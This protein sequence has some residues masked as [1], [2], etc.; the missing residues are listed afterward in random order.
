MKQKS[1]G[2]NYIYNLILTG[3]N[4]AFPL[5]TASYLSYILGA[6]NIGKV[7]YATSIINWFIIFASFGIPR[8]GVRAIARSRD[9]KKELSETFW[10][11]MSIQ[12]IFTSV[13]VCI[14]IAF[15]VNI[16]RFEEELILHLL[17]VLML[18]LN[19]FS[20][21]WFYQGI[22]E[23]GYITVRSILFK[24]I[25]IILMFALIKSRNDYII[26]AFINIIGV[27]L[28]N[29]LNY[30]HSGKFIYRK[31]PKLNI[32]HYIKE[33]R[34][35]FVTTL[36]IAIYG[37]LDQLFIGTISPE[38]L[39]YYIRSKTLL[40][41]GISVTNSV[42]TVLIPRS[43]YLMENDYKQ[44]K[45]V[46]QQS[47]NYIYI[48]GVPCVIGLIL[49]SEEVM[50]LLGGLEFLPAVSSLQI[51]SIQIIIV[52]IGGWQVNQI[53]I[54]YKKEALALKIQVLAAVFSVIL[55]IILIPMYSYIG[56]AITCTLTETLLVIIEGII[57][58]HKFTDIK[59]NYINRSMIK[60]LIAGLIMGMAIILIKQSVE[61]VSTTI[62][63][64][65]MA[66]PIIYFIIII[67]LKDELVIEILN[68]IIIKIKI[69][70][71]IVR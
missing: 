17:M 63:L 38:E 31:L 71:K 49:L 61:T 28:N 55:N 10:N 45:K 15:I 56:A 22:E 69:K 46:I 21:D 24:V 34:V 16:G 54:P 35:Y 2:K 32:L 41:V 9:S 58:K 29:I 65:G 1:I 25:S 8:Y 11:L 57:I 39:A 62:L 36:V 60:Y 26:Y 67:I 37:S 12:F 19:A 44:Y 51:I 66:A 6:E 70:S 33:L 52:S 14:Y 18:V 5:V 13:S 42:I 23:Y 4:L 48:L 40:G 68:P 53:L 7:N 64:S 30:I 59:I 20:L 27:S 50:L 47:I 3:L 43:A